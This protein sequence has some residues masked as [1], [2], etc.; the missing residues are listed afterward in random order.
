MDAQPLAYPAGGRVVIRAL[1]LGLTVFASAALAGP[2]DD[3]R[4]ERYH[5]AAAAGT[6]GSVTGRAAAEGATPKAPEQPLIG[7]SVTLLPRS[8]ALLFRFREIQRQ[9]RRDLGVYRASGSALVEARRAY[10]RALSNAGAADLVL[11]TE[12]GPDG[13]FE[14]ERV[15]AG[16]WLL[17]AQR[18]VFVSKASTSLNK[19][20]REIFLRQPRLT[21]YYTV[22]VWLRELTMVSGR[23][24]HVGLSDRNAWMIAIQE[25]RI[26]DA[27]R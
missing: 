13:T 14:L 7:V 19:R 1:L 26:L 15:P 4:T 9:A 6:V 3:V 25:E 20:D 2:V 8:E 10:E 12:V 16:D 23:S 17:I 24:E 18:A 11:Y 27:G 22:T 5:D 21:G